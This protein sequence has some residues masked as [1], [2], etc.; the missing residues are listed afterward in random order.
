MDIL[1]IRFSSLGDVVLASAAVEALV[2]RYSDARIHFLTKD[3]YAPLFAHDMRVAR[4][5]GIR[6]G[7]NPF[8]EF[9]G[10]RRGGILTTFI[11]SN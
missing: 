5:I 6:S 10:R 2:R 3:V 9:P 8:G 4:V 7:E 1:L 11:N